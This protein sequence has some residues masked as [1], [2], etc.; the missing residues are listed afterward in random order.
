[1]KR[2]TKALLILAILMQIF[3]YFLPFLNVSYGHQLFQD[4]IESFFN[5]GI[6][7]RNRYMF[8]AFFAPIFSFPILLIALFKPFPK[9]M[10]IAL[11]LVL[12]LTVLFPALFSV[13][14]VWPN[15]NTLGH[16]FWVV[17]FC[18]MY[19]LLFFKKEK[20]EKVDEDDLN[21]HLIENER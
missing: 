18:F 19:G 20:K 15:F 5:Y 8:Y 13:F 12:G 14:L 3:S 6:Q 11:N 1:M 10:K 16:V 2:R 4:G 7:T 17:S 21:H 9:A